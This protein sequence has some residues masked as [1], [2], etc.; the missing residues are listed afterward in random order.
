MNIEHEAMTVAARIATRA[1]V[2]VEAVLTAYRNAA[3]G[4][5][6]NA[7]SLFIDHAGA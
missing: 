4:A 5:A 7:Q 2:T 6:V 3:R 1:G